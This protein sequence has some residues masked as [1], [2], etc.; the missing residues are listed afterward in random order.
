MFSKE[1][2]K[3]LEVVAA[4]AEKLEQPVFLVG[5]FVRDLLLGV[6]LDGQDIDFM[7]VENVLSLAKEVCRVTGGKVNNFP[8]FATAKILQPT[9]FSEIREIDFATARTERYPAPGSLPEIEPADLAADLA[10]RDF[11]IN[12]MALPVAALLNNLVDSRVAMKEL[13]GEIVD[14]YNGRRAL[15]DRK[16]EIL[17]SISFLDDPTRIFRAC[18]YAVRINGQLEAGTADLLVQAV[19]SGALKTIAGYRCLK[20]IKKVFKEAKF[21]RVAALLEEYGVWQELGLVAEDSSSLLN[22]LKRFYNLD[23]SCDAKLR[24]QLGLR[25]F[26]YF[27]SLAKEGLSSLG[28]KPGKLEKILDDVLLAKASAPPHLLDDLPLLLRNITAQDSASN[29]ECRKRGLCP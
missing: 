7:A 23:L 28:L 16:V 27:S 14:R 24:F 15:E 9:I 12:A 10:R 11:S 5:G 6:E 13:L 20:E 4:E 29:D 8:E 2:I 21:N 25:L 18:R 26:V 19:S 1:Q 3:L 17:H 22:S